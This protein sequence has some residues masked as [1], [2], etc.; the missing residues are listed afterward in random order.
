M[1]M[2]DP[3]VD[4]A[5]ANRAAYR[6]LLEDGPNRR[7]LAAIDDLVAP[8]F[9]GH[10][11]FNAPPLKG[12]DAFR[13]WLTRSITAFP[14]WQMSLDDVLATDDKVVARWTI[15][16]TESGEHR[17]PTG[18]VQPVSGKALEV[19]GIHIARFADGLLVELWHSQDMLSTYQQLGVLPEIAH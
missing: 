7:D 2:Q 6:R 4:Q 12:R 5:A 3:A 14:D 9:V 1:T 19:R 16:G 8:G 18:E 10:W 15:R 11:L 13:G 17:S